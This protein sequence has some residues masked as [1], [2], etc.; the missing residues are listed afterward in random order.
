MDIGAQFSRIFRLPSGPLSNNKTTAVENWDVRRWIHRIYLSF[1]VR[2][3]RNTSHFKAFCDGVRP[4]ERTS[5][6]TCRI[7][8]RIN[9]GSH[10]GFAPRRFLYNIACL[11]TVNNILHT[12]RRRSI[13]LGGT[14]TRRYIG[15]V[16][17]PWM[18]RLV[19]FITSRYDGIILL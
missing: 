4:R 8:S 6:R 14:T 15:Y 16:C 17:V 18:W 19:Y 7:S 2:Y 12:R 5:A 13:V 1:V 3:T 9:L 11:S 10:A